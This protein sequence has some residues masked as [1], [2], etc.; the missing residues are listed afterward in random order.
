MAIMKD[1]T[2]KKK[3][4]R[5]LKI[6]N[7]KLQEANASKD[8]FLSI[9]AHDL[10][11]PFGAIVGVSDLICEALD[12][13]DYE[14]VSR[15]AVTL[16][17]SVKNSYDLLSNLLNW[18]RTQSKKI[19]FNPESLKLNELIQEA[20]GIHENFAKSKGIDVVLRKD[21]DHTVFADRFMITSVL[22]NLISN[23][24]K[25]SYSGGKVVISS[26]HKKNDIIVSVS[27]EGVGMEEK[28]VSGL[29]KIDENNS[30]LGTSD[31]KG[32]GLGLLLSNEF[33][34]YH[35]GRL[36][37]DSKPG[38]GSVFSFSIP[39]SEKTS[40]DEIIKPTAMSDKTILI[41]EDEEINFL[42]LKAML[43]TMKCN[44]IHAYNGAEVIESFT[45]NPAI[46]LV[47][48]DIKMPVMDGVAATKKIRQIR[49]DVPIIAQ[50][51]Y[52]LDREHH[53][54]FQGYISKPIDKADLFEIVNKYL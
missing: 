31:E 8:K 28:V 36:W 19:N 25:Y 54:L 40:T 35:Q 48:M 9:L 2:Q 43:R 30:T 20:I 33:V 42:L 6:A 29:F 47:L 39:P 16:N 49:P 14:A 23:A 15:Y 50:T 18:S 4:E 46:S 12:E 32:T 22:R 21:A 53:K 3:V 34:H 41:G 10:K 1:I 44:I 17:Q 45:Q 26:D 11:N 38:K 5:S 24:L 37:V 13:K 51:A 7:L 52:D 27:D